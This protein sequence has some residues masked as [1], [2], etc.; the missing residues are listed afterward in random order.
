MEGQRGEEEAEK[1]TQ[2]HLLESLL[3][4]RI[5]RRGYRSEPGTV[6]VNDYPR[7]ERTVDIGEI[8]FE[9]VDLLIVTSKGSVLQCAGALEPATKSLRVRGCS[10]RAGRG[11]ECQ[12]GR[13]KRGGQGERETKRTTLLVLFSMAIAKRRRGVS[14][15][16][17]EGG[18]KQRE[19][20]RPT[21]S[22]PRSVSVCKEM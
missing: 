3:P 20:A 21:R 1:K 12:N 4:R 8:R 13:L 11:R 5:R 22:P 10:E 6:K 17:G 19:D 16:T 7:S 9:P 2:T 15:T 14:T 18:R